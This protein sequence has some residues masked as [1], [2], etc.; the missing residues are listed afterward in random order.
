[1]FDATLKLI[2]GLGERR[3]SARLPRRLGVLFA[4]LAT[5]ADPMEAGETEDLIWGLWMQHDHP[6]A[7]D[8]LDHATR[9]IAAKD[10]EAAEGL[11]DELVVEEPEFAEAW[12]KR[13]TLY[14][15]LKR[16]TESV[17][18]IRRTL[19]LEPR[20]FGAICGFAQICLRHRERVAAMFAFDAALR[21]NPHLATV[22]SAMAELAAE[23]GQ[24]VH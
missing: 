20:H 2:V 17:A 6:E 9:A 4:Q 24:T 16:D 1:M 3:P 13:A 8:K 5:T 7:E 19:E 10:W 22:R 18:D 15:L 14:F 11:L 12:N 21:I 23:G